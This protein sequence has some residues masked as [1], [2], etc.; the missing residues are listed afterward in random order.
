MPVPD[1][2][3][4]LTDAWQ[5]LG[6]IG[7]AAFIGVVL[8]AAVAV[9]VG[10]AIPRILEQHLLEERAGT[11]E[12][13]VSELVADG[14]LPDASGDFAALSE[15]VRLRVLGGDT[16][17]VKLWSPDGEILWSDEPRLVGR[18]HAL[19]DDGGAFGGEMRYHV[20][21][22]ADPEHEFEQHFGS[23]LEFYMP[24]RV[25][26]DIPYVFEV[27]QQ[28]GPLAATV[29]RARRT[30]WLSI[31][32]GLGTMGVVMV[33]MAAAAVASADRRRRQ[34]EH[35]LDLLAAVRDEE[36]TRLANAM[37]DD[38]GQPLY[39]L[40]YGLEALQGIVSGEAGREVRTLR[41]IVR[42]IDDTIRGE[43]HRLQLPALAGRELA[44]ALYD[45]AHDDP[46]H[47]PQVDVYVDGAGSTH[48]GTAEVLY[49]GVR[50]AVANARRHAG[51]RSIRIS[52]TTRDDRLVAV[53][54]DDGTGTPGSPGLGSTLVARMLADVGGRVDTAARPGVGTTVTMSVPAEEP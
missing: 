31:A 53:V 12:R 24:V 34:A 54:S 22:L 7:R 37:H 41:S 9:A 25:G 13:V 44:E 14:A 39:R 42:D 1:R 23:L 17:R 46:R 35:M 5:E 16:V 20:S 43:L 21:S 51:A 3:A 19:P 30:V 8:F 47:P 6:R 2:L 27:Y 11:L 4:R 28:V 18:R 40:L 15:F 48:P 26:D 52:L 36:R 29:G 45:M 49:R 33:G 32:L 38:M 50:E 10:I